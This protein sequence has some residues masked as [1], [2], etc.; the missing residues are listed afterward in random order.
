MGNVAAACIGVAR[1]LLLAFLSARS[2]GSLSGRA[3][4]LPTWRVVDAS[5]IVS[6]PP[7]STL[8]P[9]RSSP[10][11]SQP[12]GRDPPLVE[13]VPMLVPTLVCQDACRFVG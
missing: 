7:T 5:A 9:S 3:S 2:P 6:S 11:R 12:V 13:C 4:R 8:A 10:L 1:A